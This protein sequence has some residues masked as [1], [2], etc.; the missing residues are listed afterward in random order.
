MGRLSWIICVGPKCNY[1][2]PY[3]REA[4]GDFTIEEKGHVMTEAERSSVREI[5]DTIPLALKQE[6]KNKS[7]VI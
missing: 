1:K 2:C 6:K 3:K 4:E 5:E 7:Q